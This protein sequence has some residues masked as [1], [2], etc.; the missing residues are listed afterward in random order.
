M[1]IKILAISNG[2]FKGLDLMLIELLL[3]VRFDIKIQEQ[4]MMVNVLNKLNCVIKNG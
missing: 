3:V 2:E 4:I 1:N